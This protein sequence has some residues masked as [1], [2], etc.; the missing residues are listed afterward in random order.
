MDHDIKLTYKIDIL[1]NLDNFF[2]NNIGLL[3][4][5]QKEDCRHQN[6]IYDCIM[7]VN[8]YKIAYTT[9]PGSIATGCFII[10]NKAINIITEFQEYPVYGFDDFRLCESILGNKLICGVF[11]DLY[12][13]HPFDLIDEN[14]V[15]RL[16]KI[17][18]IINCI[19]RKNLNYYQQ[20][21]ES[22]KFWNIN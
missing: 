19:E 10:P 15:Y 21:Q 20:I 4:F 13:V 7:Y 14:N 12:V 8:N 18:S 2:D 11:T 6:N 22:H 17:N 9:E 16:W 1:N 3:A 5:N